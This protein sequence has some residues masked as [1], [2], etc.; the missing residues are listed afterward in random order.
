MLTAVVLHISQFLSDL[1]LTVLV[2]GGI[3]I[4]TF[5]SIQLIDIQVHAEIMLMTALFMSEAAFRQPASKT[6]R[7]TPA[8]IIYTYSVE[9][10]VGLFNL[11]YMF[12]PFLRLS[13]GMS[14]QKS[15][16]GRYNEIKC[17]W[18]LV[19]RHHLLIIFKYQVKVKLTIKQATKG[20]RGSRCIALIFL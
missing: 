19:C 15:F 6:K 17:M 16:K 10:K 9:H 13:S 2:D 5:P 1:R 14:I 8:A 12:R 18:S 7:I 4:L 11:G 20:Q 3:C